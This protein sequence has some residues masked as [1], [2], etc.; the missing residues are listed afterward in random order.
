MGDKYIDY[1]YR[2]FDIEKCYGLD[3]GRAQQQPEPGCLVLITQAELT[4]WS[5]SNYVLSHDTF[6][7]Q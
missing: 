6:P 3:E 7:V 2:R 4:V 1:D 5:L